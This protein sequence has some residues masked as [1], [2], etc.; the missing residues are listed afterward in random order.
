MTHTSKGSEEGLR[1]VV[2]QRVLEELD[3]VAVSGKEHNPEERRRV[4]HVVD[5]LA[6]KVE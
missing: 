3:S 4:D 2:R 6:Q 5:M 1:R